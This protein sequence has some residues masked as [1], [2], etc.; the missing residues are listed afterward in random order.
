MLPAK[1]MVY[2]KQSCPESVCLYVPTTF[3]LND[4]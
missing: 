1:F 4:L 3:E 2:L